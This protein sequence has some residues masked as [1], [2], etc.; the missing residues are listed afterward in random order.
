M[1]LLHL[2]FIFLVISLWMSSSAQAQQTPVITGT[3]FSI[4]E[5]LHLPSQVLNEDRV[6]N[7]YL[8]SDYAPDSV[9][10]HVLYLF[11]G[12]AEEDFIHI[13]GLVQFATFPWINMMP[14]TI[15]VGIGNT[16]RFR[17]FTSPAETDEFRNEF[18][19]SGGSEAFMDFME[20]EVIPL[21]EE[22]YAVDT[23]ST[24]IGQSMGG[25][26]ATEVLL[27]RPGLFDQYIIVSP[28]LWWNDGSMLKAG[29]KLSGVEG[30][31]RKVC[32]A[33][34]EEGDI[35]KGAARDLKN[36]LQASYPDQAEVSYAYYPEADHG[37]VL[38]LAA[39]NAI[40][41]LFPQPAKVKETE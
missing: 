1:K 39:Y 41:S 17:D 37:N 33:V 20:K 19:A 4:G 2:P 30:P 24:L 18:P 8:P 29:H 16:E 32:I 9:R 6:L 12:S 28:S 7:I 27:T 21:V 22:R 14:P 31:K 26:M 13:A 3:P 10:Y 34:G 15:V 40:L 23:L 25:L 36:L 11:D 35:M 5:T 38:H